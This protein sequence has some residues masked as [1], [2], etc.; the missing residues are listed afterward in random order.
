MWKTLYILV[1]INIQD[2]EIVLFCT[3]LWQME[4]GTSFREHPV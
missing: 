2:N 3:V 1:T 4:M